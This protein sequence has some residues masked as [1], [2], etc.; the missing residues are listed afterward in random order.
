ME[1]IHMV[2]AD[3]LKTPTPSQ[4]QQIPQISLVLSDFPRF[5]ILFVVLLTYFW[6]DKYER[7]CVVFLLDR[8]GELLKVGVFVRLLLGAQLEVGREV[9]VHVSKH[10][11]ARRIHATAAETVH[12]ISGL[13]I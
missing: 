11:C 10:A 7:A 9:A 12:R 2:R 13:F 6:P 4:I 1:K 8:G 5:S 3:H